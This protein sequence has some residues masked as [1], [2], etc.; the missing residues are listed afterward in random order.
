[1][2]WRNSRH[3]YKT[4]WIKGSLDQVHH[5]GDVQQSSSRRRI[6]LFECAWTIDPSM[7][8]LSR[9]SILSLGSIFYSIN[10]LEPGCFLKLISD[11]AIIRSVFDPRIYP[12]PHSPLG[13]G[14]LNTWLCW[15]NKC[16]SPLHIL[17]EFGI[18]A[19]VRQVCG[20]LH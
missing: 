5:R 1:M 20:G 10:S 4:C 7:K 15:S 12:R 18:H 14:Y 9:T 8:L 17:D 11:R 16:S 2:N 19:R 13:M 6:K 3:N